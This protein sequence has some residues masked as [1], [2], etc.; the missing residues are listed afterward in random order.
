MLEGIDTRSVRR[1]LVRCS[2]GM[3]ATLML[4]AGAGPHPSV[5]LLHDS[6][7][8]GLHTRDLAMRLATEGYASICPNLYHR[9]A[10]DSETDRET[11]VPPLRD[12]LVVELVDVAV[13]HLRG[14]PE[15]SAERL[16]VMGLGVTGRHALL[17]ATQRDDIAACVTLYGAAGDPAPG[18][19][20]IEAIIPRLRT[21]V[22]GVFAE[23]DEHVSL[24]QVHRFRTA[25]EQ[26]RRSY[27][28][29]VVPDVRNGF[30]DD[31]QPDR[32][33]RAPAEATWQLL[34]DFLSRVHSGGYPP[35]RA[36]WTFEGS[37]N[38]RYDVSGRSR[39]D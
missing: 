27:H 6:E 38:P 34:V 9:D 4:P 18:Q 35:D 8:N 30:L 1:E 23:Y 36:R 22:L 3:V 17:V 7:G 33:R 29:R 5:V 19:E 20:P 14:V 12:D 15:A 31:T 21:P 39:P 24:D 26:A 10:N 11:G 28:L 32:Y 13:A 16:T 37:T 25:L 2:N